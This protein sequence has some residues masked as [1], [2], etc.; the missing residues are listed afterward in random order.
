MSEPII[1]FLQ[2]ARSAGIRVSVA[3]SIDA[4]NALDLIGFDDRQ[5][6]KDSLSLLLAKTRDEKQLFEE[7]FDLY[8]SRKN[9]TGGEANE[10]A[11]GGQQDQEQRGDAEAG[12]GQAEG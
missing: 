9:F 8:F 12:E 6:M 1:K 7:C 2:A 5:T 10:N 3:E 11:S 4:Y